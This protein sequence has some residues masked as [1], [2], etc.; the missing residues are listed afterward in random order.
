MKDLYLSLLV[1]GR[2]I[3][4]EVDPSHERR[5]GVFDDVPLRISNPKGLETRDHL[6]ELDVQKHYEKFSAP[7]ASFVP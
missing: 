2:M 6:E 7:D 3:D 1:L 4:Y 5:E